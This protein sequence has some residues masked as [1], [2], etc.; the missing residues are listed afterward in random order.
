[1]ID[2]SLTE[3]QRQIVETAREFGREVLGPA[4][5]ELDLIANPQETFRSERFWNVLSQAFGLGFH[6]MGLAEA[7]GGLGLDPNTTGLAWEELGRYGPGLAASLLAGAAAHQ[8][9]A[10]LASHNR[11]LME[12]YVIPFCEDQT[13][14]RISAWGSSEPNL[15]SEGSN[16]DDLTVRHHT[17]AVRSGDR[18]VLNGTKS[19]FVSNGGIADVYVVFACVEPSRG[20]RGSGAFVVPA[21]A[22]GVSR[23]TPLDKIGLRTLNQTP[24]FFE[25]VEVP[26]SY[27]IFPPGEDYPA[28]HNAI[29]TVG[30]LGVGYLAVGLMRAAYEEALAYARERVQW[31]KPI[32][33]H[34]LITKKFFDLHAAIESARALLWK[35]S[36]LCK[37]A[38]PGDL[39]TSL[40][41]KI[42]ATNA[43]VRHTAEMVQVL[44]GY[45]ISRE[46]PL[47][48]YARDAQLLPIMDGTNE[49]LLLK[50]AARF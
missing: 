39:K 45:G 7:Y 32:F 27:M 34:Q 29:I 25:N 36:W 22:A 4:E 8:I 12:R 3:T 47:E 10:L 37:T 2:F 5:I 16:Y 14:R 48:K 19:N 30:N 40:T 33:Q 50:A 20:L 13:G 21:E 1:M 15:G 28:L 24:V 26:A 44:G 49:T 18:H 41:A 23:G 11:E 6:K 17:T 43:A 38:F 46:Y 9:I 31:G 35:A 42:Y